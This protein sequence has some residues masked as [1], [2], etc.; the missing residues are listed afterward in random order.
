MKTQ[1]TRIFLFGLIGLVF[2][3]ACGNDPEFIFKG[4]E[5]IVVSFNES[6][7]SIEATGEYTGPAAALKA[8]LYERPTAGQEIK[9]EAVLD[10]DRDGDEKTVAVDWKLSYALSALPQTS[11]EFRLHLEVTEEYKEDIIFVLNPDGSIEILEGPADS[12]SI[13]PQDSEDSD[14]EETAEETGEESGQTSEES[15]GEVD[16]VTFSLFVHES[17]L[18]SAT[19]VFKEG[20]GF[21]DLFETGA[22]DTTGFESL[23]LSQQVFLLLVFSENST[24]SLFELGPASAVVFLAV[25]NDITGRELVPLNPGAAGDQSFLYSIPAGKADTGE[26]PRVRIEVR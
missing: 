20:E 21:T 25:R 24:G 12:G 8:D 19:V 16:S 17:V 14:G 6:N 10:E 13:T 7:M 4:F 18:E 9:R 23:E 22:A 15:G 26:S 3:S 1:T 5:D 2:L 11:V